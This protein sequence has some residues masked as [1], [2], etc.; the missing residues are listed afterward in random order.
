MKSRTSIA[1]RLRVWRQA[2]EASALR[3]ERVPTV[4]EIADAVGV[5]DVLAV[6]A[7]DV[8]AGPAVV[9]ADAVAMA[10]VVVDTGTRQLML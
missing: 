6:V 3:A 2:E 7:G 10:A 8:D 9:A 1:M 5:A 4:V